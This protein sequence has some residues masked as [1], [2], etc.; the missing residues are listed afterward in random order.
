M[1]GTNNYLKQNMFPV[2]IIIIIIIIIIINNNNNNNNVFTSMSLAAR[3]A[4]SPTCAST[5]ALP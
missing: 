2:F 1:Q 3:F 5:S 4:S